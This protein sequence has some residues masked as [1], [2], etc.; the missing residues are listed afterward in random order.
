MQQF[1]AYIK[2][3]AM[4]GAADNSFQ[5]VKAGMIPLYDLGPHGGPKYHQRPQNNWK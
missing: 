3:K 1:Q 4:L 2:L 5:L